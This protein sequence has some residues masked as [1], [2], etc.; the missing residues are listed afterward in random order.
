MNND[1]DNM[2]SK[3]QFKDTLNPT[4]INFTDKGT[5]IKGNS[6]CP[7]CQGYIW[8]IKFDPDGTYNKSCFEC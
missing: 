7:D 3:D 1:T 6:S 4:E 5:F 2:L 8:N